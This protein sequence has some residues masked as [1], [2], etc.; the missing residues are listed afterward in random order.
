MILSVS[1]VVGNR[2][3]RKGERPGRRTG[4]LDHGLRCGGLGLGVVS[5]VA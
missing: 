5:A 3:A 4:R 1:V 2:G